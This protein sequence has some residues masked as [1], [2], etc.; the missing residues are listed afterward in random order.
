MIKYNL[1]YID[2]IIRAKGSCNILLLLF[3]ISLFTSCV[4]KMLQP[5]AAPLGYNMSENHQIS[6]KMLK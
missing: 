1:W 6:Y 3:A 4:N 5:P 2:R